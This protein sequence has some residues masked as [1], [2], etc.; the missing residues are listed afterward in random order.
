VT[1]SAELAPVRV[2]LFAWRF[3]AEPEAESPAFE[4]SNVVGEVLKSC[5]EP[6][7]SPP[8]PCWKPPGMR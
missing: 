1:V 4:E 5:A 8:L 7:K 2:C 6:T 3:E